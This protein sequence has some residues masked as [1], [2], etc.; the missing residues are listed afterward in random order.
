[1]QRG[2]VIILRKDN[3]RGITNRGCCEV[4]EYKLLAL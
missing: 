4:Q 3:K 1:M 2:F